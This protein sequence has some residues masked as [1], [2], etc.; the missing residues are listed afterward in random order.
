MTQDI[1]IDAGLE[2]PNEG[3]TRKLS[4][5]DQ[6]DQILTLTFISIPASRV[7]DQLTSKR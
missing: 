3:T 6:P 1:G 7:N 5:R 2:W 4:D